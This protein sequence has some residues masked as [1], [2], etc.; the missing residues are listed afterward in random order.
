M[1]RRLQANAWSSGT[2][3]GQVTLTRELNG[4]PMERSISRTVTIQ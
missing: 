3:S 1:G 4:H 2:D